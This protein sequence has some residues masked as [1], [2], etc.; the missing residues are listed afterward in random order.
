MSRYFFTGGMMPAVDLVDR[1]DVPLEVEE[2]WNVSG[3]AL[4]AH[5]RGL[6][7]EPRVGRKRELLPVLRATY[8]RGRGAS[9]GSTAGGSS[10]WP[11]RSSSATRSGNEWM[12]GP[13][14]AA[15]RSRRP[16]ARMTTLNRFD[17]EPAQPARRASSAGSTP[18]PST[19]EEA[20][21]DPREIDWL[22]VVPF[23][24]LHAEL[25]RS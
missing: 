1:L 17:A 18:G 7:A 4:R 2:R 11:A 15:R 25:L 10:S 9:S 13:P 6:A 20:E 5:V 19:S 24:L 14:A 23:L 3:T 21:R 16:G 22:R 8:G 12:R